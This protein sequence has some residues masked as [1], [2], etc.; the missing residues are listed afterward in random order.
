[1]GKFDYS[2]YRVRLIF[3]LANFALF[4]AIISRVCECECDIVVCQDRLGAL[5]SMCNLEHILRAHM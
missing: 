4:F 2:P 5:E 1:M 3:M